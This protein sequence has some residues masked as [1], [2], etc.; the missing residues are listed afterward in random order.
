MRDMP[1]WFQGLVY[2]EVFAQLPFFFLATYAFIYGKNWIRI[3][4]LIYGVE[5][6]TSMVCI[7]GHILFDPSIADDKRQ[8]LGL[9][10]CPYLFLPLLLSY[11][12]AVSAEPF[13]DSNAKAKAH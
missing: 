13:K 6:V 2:I 4:A 5:V 11:K 3:P 12:M 8:M 9:I 7:L 1:A 10:Y